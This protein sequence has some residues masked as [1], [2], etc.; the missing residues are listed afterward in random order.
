M[1][2]DKPFREQIELRKRPQWG[3]LGLS[4]QMSCAN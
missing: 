4:W 3:K 1:S 2:W